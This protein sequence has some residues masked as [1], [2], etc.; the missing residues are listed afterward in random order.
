[1]IPKFKDFYRPFLE[2]LY[3]N[4][5]MTK[6]GI[7]K[8]IA[9]SMHLSKMAMTMTTKGGSNV[10]VQRVHW[11]TVYMMKAGMIYRIRRGVYAITE[12]GVSLLK[13]HSGQID[14]YVLASVSKEFSEYQYIKKTTDNSPQSK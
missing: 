2:V 14:N 3:Y 13:N 11:A 5:P 10:I 9:L 12:E 8:E 6:Y 1:M 4:G 7:T